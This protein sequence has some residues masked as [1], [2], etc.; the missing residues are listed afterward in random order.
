MRRFNGK[1]SALSG[2]TVA[3]RDNNVDQAMRKLKKDM[4]GEGVFR[5]MKEDAVGYVP[6]SERK[7]VKHN[8]AVAR[9]KKIADKAAAKEW[10]VSLQ[11]YRAMKRSGPI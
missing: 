4:Q 8:K 9:Q 7:R 2:F 10:G 6:K 11:E 1:P 5:R 3:V